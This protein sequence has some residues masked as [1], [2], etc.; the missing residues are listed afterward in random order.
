MPDGSPLA[1][2]ASTRHDGTRRR[3]IGIRRHEQMQTGCRHAGSDPIVRTLLHRPPAVPDLRAGPCSAPG[4][5]RLPAARSR[6]QRGRASIRAPIRSRAGGAE[7]PARRCRPPAQGAPR[8]GRG[9]AACSARLRSRQGD[10]RLRWA[11]GS[12]EPRQRSKAI[13][14]GIV[15]GIEA[16]ESTPSP[17]ASRPPAA[18]WRHTP[19]FRYRRPRE[20]ADSDQLTGHGRATLACRDTARQFARAG[21]RPWIVVFGSAGV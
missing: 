1:R 10:E 15:D 18:G 16:R 9:P 20:T 17:P 3:D 5:D 2:D 13:S 19:R 8:G 4:A 12:A 7:G 6:R 14:G 11:Q 21:P